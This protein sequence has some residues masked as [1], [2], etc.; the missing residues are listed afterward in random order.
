LQNPFATLC[1]LFIFIKF[2][3]LGRAILAI[4]VCRILIAGAILLVKLQQHHS[5]AGKKKG[6]LS[7]DDDGLL[8]L[9][10]RFTTSGHCFST[11]D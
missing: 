7:S 11:S 10:L 4:L 1:H 2:L 9:E 5:D 8:L 3:L 6:S